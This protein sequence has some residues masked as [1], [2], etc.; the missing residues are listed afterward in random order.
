MPDDSKVL[1]TATEIVP[2]GFKNELDLLENFARIDVNR[3]DCVRQVSHRDTYG[4][5]VDRNQTQKDDSANRSHVLRAYRMSMWT[6]DMFRS[7]F[8]RD[9]L[10]GS[11]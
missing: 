11:R 10:N 2:I 9:V 6:P 8:H 3:R 7:N 5:H 4:T 1:T